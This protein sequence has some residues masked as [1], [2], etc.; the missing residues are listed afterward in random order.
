MRSLTSLWFMRY[1]IDMCGF[2]Y[3][4]VDIRYE[5]YTDDFFY[6]TVRRLA[7]ARESN[8]LSVIL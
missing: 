3:L 7:G 4:G 1:E 6:H 2:F 8:M 5:K